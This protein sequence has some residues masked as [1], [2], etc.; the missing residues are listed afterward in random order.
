MKRLQPAGETSDRRVDILIEA[1]LVDSLGPSLNTMASDLLAEGYQVSL[2]SVSGSSPES[3]RSFLRAEYDS[4]LV[5][6]VFVGELPVAW[7][8]IINDFQGN[9]SNDGYEEFP[10]DLYF[11]DLDGTWRDDS[12]RY[13]NQDSLVPGSDGIYDVHVD[14]VAPEI[15]ISRLHAST[16]G[17]EVSLLRGYLDKAHR[18][19]AGRLVVSDRALVY[20]D[21]DWYDSA[22]RWDRDVGYL[23]PDRVSIWDPE[24]TRAADYRP[25][26]DSAGYEW[27]QLCAH[28]S[29]AVH[30]WKYN[31]GQS[32]DR[33]YATEIGVVDPEA[34]FYNLFC[35]SNVR[36]VT[37]GYMGGRYVF[38]TTKGLAAIGSCKTGSMLEFGQFYRPLST[39]RSLSSAFTDW[40]R[41]R[42]Q[43]GFER[44][45][46]SWFYGMA[47][48]GDGLLRPRLNPT[49]MREFGEPTPAPKLAVSSPMSARL[50][51]RLTAI[52]AG[53]ITVSLADRSGRV[54]FSRGQALSKGTHLIQADVQGLPA[55]V[56]LLSVDSQSGRLDRPV[57]VLR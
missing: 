36:Y 13:S 47:L 40:F 49:G 38:E 52:E 12:L 55:G 4:G 32:W 16:L 30:A 34:C 22:P 10:C 8:Q 21:D 31:S 33:F 43:D 19:R 37:A 6:A 42:A 1:E 44:W 26:V 20:I 53:P 3:L 23:Y 35:C 5:H 46:R 50:S 41:Y 17:D 18:Y 14:S 56:Y 29:P 11:M 51:F 54:V 2:L 45:E 25:R 9:G 27:L 7:F 57:V 28:S 15:G 39:G 48:I 24:S